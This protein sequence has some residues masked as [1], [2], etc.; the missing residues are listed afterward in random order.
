MFL[1]I[2][3]HML[4]GVDDGCVNLSESIRCVRTLMDHGF[5]GTV[6]TSHMC[7]AELPTITPSFVHE[8]ATLLRQALRREGLDYQIF[9]GGE[10]RL[11]PLTVSWF[12]QHGVPSLGD[13]R[14]V[15]VDTWSHW[16]DYCDEAIDY[17]EDNGYQPILAHP[18]RM[19]IDEAEWHRLIDDLSERGVWLQGN[20]KPIGGRDM[21][22]LQERAL[23][24]L[25]EGRYKVIALD[26]HRP[27][28]LA[29]RLVGLDVIRDRFGEDLLSKLL[30]D[31]PAEIIA[32]AAE[33]HR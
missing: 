16:E 30:A 7:V 18:E 4:P 11:Q 13:G 21:P 19:P 14:C 28:G 12:Q 27:K 33:S 23:R 1:D 32:P 31:A 15:L 17:L 29:E 9:T 22:G 6:C 5:G 10:V 3:S 20:L 2:H 8:Q 26:M 25:D 24:L